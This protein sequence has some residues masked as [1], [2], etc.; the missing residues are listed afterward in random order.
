VGWPR[1]WRIF[2]V[3][4]VVPSALVLS[5]VQQG[6]VCA[7]C[8]EC[9]GRN[10]VQT[11]CVRSRI[12]CGGEELAVPRRRQ[13]FGGFGGIEDLALARIWLPPEFGP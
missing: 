5:A 8:S 2:G 13:G 11:A 7:V 4:I 6:L 1:I 12:V 3:V 10:Q 9:Q